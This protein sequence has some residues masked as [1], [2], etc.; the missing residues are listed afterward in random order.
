MMDKAKRYLKNT[1]YTKP[2]NAVDGAIKNNYRSSEAS[3]GKAINSGKEFGSAAKASFD[4]LR[5]KGSSSAMAG[6]TV[7]KDALGMTPKSAAVGMAAGGTYGAMSDDTSILGGMAMGGVA[8]F[9]AVK[10]AKAIHGRY[11][12]K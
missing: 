4:D 2:L 11:G 10:G 8:G 6:A 9:G 12:S 3:F 1:L 5:G 7:A